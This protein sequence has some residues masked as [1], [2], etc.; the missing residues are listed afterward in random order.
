[1]K[2][3]DIKVCRTSD[4]VLGTNPKLS[5]IPDGAGSSTGCADILLHFIKCLAVMTSIEIK[6]YACNIE[7]YIL[8]N[9]T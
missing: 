9:Y 3:K 4:A 2:I 1:M 7:C 6:L 8:H 5:S